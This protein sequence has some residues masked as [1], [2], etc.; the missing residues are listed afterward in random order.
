MQ[1]R[2]ASDDGRLLE[3]ETDVPLRCDF[4]LDWGRRLNP[5]IAICQEPEY[6]NDPRGEHC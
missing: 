2:I 4:P 6:G 1:P 5:T 3:R